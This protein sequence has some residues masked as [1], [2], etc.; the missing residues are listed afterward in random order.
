MLQPVLREPAAHFGWIESSYMSKRQAPSIKA[1][2][3]VHTPLSRCKQL[4]ERGKQDGQDEGKATVELTSTTGVS[5]TLQPRPVLANQ[6]L[7]AQFL[8]L[9]P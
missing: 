6:P 7:L 2:V 3:P 9:S 5:R 1:A 8:L 4:V